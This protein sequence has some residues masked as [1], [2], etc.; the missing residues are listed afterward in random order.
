MAGIGTN[1]EMSLPLL[2][3]PLR[4]ADTGQ[5][6]KLVLTERWE[7]GESGPPEQHGSSGMWSKGISSRH[8]SKQEHTGEQDSGSMQG[9][10]PDRQIGDMD[11]MSIILGLS[12]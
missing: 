9:S 5:H 1:R 2:L 10:W 4:I 7:K 12:V 8:D 6:T 3:L 11:N